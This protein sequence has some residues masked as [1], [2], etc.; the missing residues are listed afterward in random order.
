MFDYPEFRG[1][2]IPTWGGLL[3]WLLPMDVFRHIRDDLRDLFEE[4]YEQ[5]P[6]VQ[7][8]YAPVA[9]PE[10]KRDAKRRAIK[11]RNY[12]PSNTVTRAKSLVSGINEMFTMVLVFIAFVGT[13]LGYTFLASLAREGIGLLQSVESVLISLALGS[14]GIFGLL[15]LLF[16]PWLKAIAMSPTVVERFNQGLVIGPREIVR[17][18]DKTELVGVIV[19]NDSLIGPGAMKLVNIFAIFWIFS[20]IPGWNPYNYLLEKLKTHMDVFVEV[21]SYREAARV[22]YGRIRPNF[23]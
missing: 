6:S 20:A 12:R 4:A 19:W 21:D 17:T 10:L 11:A 15:S 5:S 8:E 18:D 9:I 7:Q 3:N 14:S 13:S 23:N 2:W 22:L 16:L 1:M